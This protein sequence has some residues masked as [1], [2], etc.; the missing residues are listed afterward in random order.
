MYYQPISLSFVEGPDH[1]FAGRLLEELRHKDKS[2]IADAG[3]P[4]GDTKVNI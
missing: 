1:D 2:P 4:K 3:E